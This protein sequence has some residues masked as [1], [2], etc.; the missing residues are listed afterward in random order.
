M[1]K[2][3]NHEQYRLQLAQQAVGLFSQYGY[4]GL[5]MRQ[6]AKQL[7]ISKGALYHYFPSKRALFH[8]CTQLVTHLD[9]NKQLA[10]V[11]SLAPVTLY[12]KIHTLINIFR[13]LEPEFPGEM[14]LLLDYLRGRTSQDIAKDPSMQLANQRYD[15]L[16]KHFVN[17]KDSKPVLCLL[18][19]TLLLRYF[20]GGSTSF[21]DIESWLIEM[22]ENDSI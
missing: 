7:G 21:D 15:S 14:S 20:D 12:D 6:I 2:K 11:D 9:N 4:S 1:P 18:L 10:N 8:T 16:V 19:G 13:E 5:G 17:E 22:L 3:I